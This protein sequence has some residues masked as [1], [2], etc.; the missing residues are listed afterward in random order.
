M[1][2]KLA[3]VRKI[4]SVSPIEGADN[5]EKVTIDGWQCVC[6]KGDFKPGDLCIYF[7][8]DSFLPIRPEYEFLRKSCYKKLEDGTEGFRIKTIKLKGVLSQGLALPLGV[9]PP[10]EFRNTN[11]MVSLIE[12]LRYLDKKEGDD[13]T[14]L[15]GVTKYEPPLPAQLLGKLKSFPDFLL[16]TDLERVQNIWEQIKDVRDTFEVT[17]KL[18]GMSC[19]YYYYDGKFGVCSKNYE[20]ERDD[21]H[22][23]W[24]IAKEYD[25]ENRL[26]WHHQSTGNHI[27]LQ[28]EIIGEGIQGNPEKIRRQDFYVFDIYHIDDLKYF[29]PINRRALIS[30]LTYD[31]FTHAKP[32][33]HILELY[34]FTKLNDFLSLDDILE[35]ANGISINSDMREGI[36]FKSN[37]SDIRFKVISDEYLLKRER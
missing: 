21:S 35:Y 20:I 34:C 11:L 29:K 1:D 30:S 13:V 37:I 33:N 22:T 2:R 24:K 36:V 16:K 26:K 25:I 12:A 14:H 3:S 9:L 18:D 19:T 4:S 31:S 7:E 15:L 10:G 32:I 8:I 5:I 28:G 17:I 27:A 23:L 6:Q